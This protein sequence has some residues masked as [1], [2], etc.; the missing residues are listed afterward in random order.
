MTKRLFGTTRG[1]NLSAILMATWLG[2]CQGASPDGM[3]AG[4]SEI[5]AAN[6]LTSNGLTSNGLT[7]NGLTSNGLTSNGLTS[8]KL[9][10]TTLTALRDKT[11]T[12]DTTR[13]FFRYLVSCALPATHSM[14]YTWTDSAGVVHTETN[15]GGFGLAPG[16]ETGAVDL[17]GQEWVSACLFAR[18]N[19]LG[20]SVPI[21]IRGGAQ[22]TLAATAQERLDYPFGEGA[23]WGNLFLPIPIARSCH[24]SALQVGATTSTDLKNGRTCAAQGCGIIFHVGPCYQSATASLGQACFD[25]AA[26]NDWVSDCNS[27]M[28][29][30]PISSEHVIT[31]WLRP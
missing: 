2:A 11:A 24:R 10:P 16:W 22:P 15:P 18:T 30:S 28:T 20:V 1:I 7:S 25:R 21:S 19:S 6:G 14:S 12:G 4:E 13:I 17:S 31:T 27:L 9:T 23:F 8:N 3:A 29:V 5:L 26:N